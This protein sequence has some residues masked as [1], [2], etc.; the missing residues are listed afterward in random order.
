MSEISDAIDGPIEPVLALEY[1]WR[2][3]VFAR[4]GKRFLRDDRADFG[5]GDGIAV[6]GGVKIPAVG[7]NIMV[8]YAFNT[9]DPLGNTHTFSLEL[10]N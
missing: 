5:F 9:R 4:G 2:D 6:G 7:R 8:D 3:R 1:G 10:G